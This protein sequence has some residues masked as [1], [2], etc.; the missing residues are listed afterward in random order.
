MII[1]SSEFL[2]AKAS[3]TLPEAAISLYKNIKFKSKVVL[4][5]SLE[6]FESPFS[7]IYKKTKSF[8]KKRK[9]PII[10]FKTE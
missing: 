8:Y 4:K 7:L 1:Q 2:L 9:S 6:F 3:Q 10:F 5:L